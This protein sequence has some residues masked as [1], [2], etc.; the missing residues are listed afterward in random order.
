MGSGS[1]G[2]VIPGKP[3]AACSPAIGAGAGDDNS[4]K[5]GVD[6]DFTDGTGAGGFLTGG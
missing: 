5:R 2:T 1:P 3:G 6:V 4:K